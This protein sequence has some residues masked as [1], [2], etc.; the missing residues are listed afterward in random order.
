V[1][2]LAG[3]GT[4]P[5]TATGPARFLTQW[6]RDPNLPPGGILV[7]RVLHPHLAPLLLT[8]A[9]LVLE[10]PSR[11]QHG[12]TLA[13]ELGVP[14]V[15]GV[16]GAAD[17]LRDGQLVTIDGSTGVIVVETAADGTSRPPC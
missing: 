15:V 6:A 2:G 7:G 12:T 13:L 5:G 16:A 4:A 1:T 14:C 8:A 10:E 11:L 3:T 9:G 17:L